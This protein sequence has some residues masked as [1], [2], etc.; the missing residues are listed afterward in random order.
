MKRFCRWH[1]PPRSFP[2]PSPTT[3]RPR[4]L[5]PLAGWTLTSISGF[6]QAFA[7]A[8]DSAVVIR[9]GTGEQGGGAAAHRPAPAH[10]GHGLTQ[11]VASLA[12]GVAAGITGVVRAPY[13]VGAACRWRRWPEHVPAPAHA[14]ACVPL[15]APPCCHRS[16][17]LQQRQRHAGRPG[18]R[19]AGRCGPASQVRGHLLHSA[20]SRG[21][22]PLAAGCQCCIPMHA[23]AAAPL[24]SLP[25]PACSGALELVGSVSA[26]LASSTGVVFVPRHRRGGRLMAGRGAG[27]QRGRSGGRQRRRAAAG[28]WRALHSGGCGTAHATSPLCLH[29]RCR[30]AQQA[31]AAV[32]WGVT[33][34]T[35]RCRLPLCCRV[36]TAC[37]AP[38]LPEVLRCSGPS[39]SSQTPQWC[40][41]RRV[42]SKQC[43]CCPC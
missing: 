26:G 38:T 6:S 15:T 21:A 19:A 10:L 2:C 5:L 18:A 28:S 8:M 35:W 30:A 9:S 40:C 13:Q 39:C 32:G 27:G 25:A 29:T 34:R 4:A 20:C 37:G 7:R 16:A 11:G 24:P 41:L 43:W 42:G 17:G 14:S 12:E 3:R 22:A 31:A 33:R 23:H 36:P 1:V